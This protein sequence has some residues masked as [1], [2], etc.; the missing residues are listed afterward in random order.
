MQD[1]GGIDKLGRFLEVAGVEV[2]QR[3]PYRASNQEADP[4]CKFLDLS[5]CTSMA[6]S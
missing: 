1:R 6:N 4:V 2:G 5:L 3:S